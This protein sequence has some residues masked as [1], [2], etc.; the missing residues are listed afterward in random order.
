MADPA[1]AAPPSP[2]PA[3]ASPAPAPVLGSGLTG[4]RY[5]APITDQAFDRLGPAGPIPASRGLRNQNNNPTWQPRA[6]S[7]RIP[8]A[9]KPA[10]APGEPPAP[11]PPASVT[12]DG[13]LQVGEYEL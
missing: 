9:P 4:V 10:A 11:A 3:P 7:R 5:D 12:E 6:I 8:G 2:A 13:K 1:P